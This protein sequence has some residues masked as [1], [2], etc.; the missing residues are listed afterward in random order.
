MTSRDPRTVRTVAALQAALRESLATE[1]LDDISVSALCRIAGVQRTTFYT[2][3]ESIAAL[4]TEMLTGE[5][6]TALDVSET[7]GKSVEVVA[8][9]FHAAV[10]AAFELVALDRRLFRVGFESDASAPLRRSLTAMFARRVELALAFWRS[11]GAGAETDVAVATAFASGGLAASFEAWASSD[12]KD[13]ARWAGATRDQM[14]PWW[15]RVL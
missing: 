7:E 10:I 8:A 15:P 4:L 5:V 9:D 6:D 13:A 12:E 11:L 1:S 2:H 14:A 3:Y